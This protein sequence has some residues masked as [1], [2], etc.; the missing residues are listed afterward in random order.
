MRRRQVDR[1]I[2]RNAAFWDWR[3][4]GTGRPPSLDQGS[5]A[6]HVAGN[7][8]EYGIHIPGSANNSMPNQCDPADQHV[9]N[10]G[11][12]EV[13]KNAAEAS[14]RVA[15][16]SSIACTLRAMPSAS[17]SSGSRAASWMRR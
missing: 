11:A 17:S 9:A 2:P 5:N 10:T 1:P 8:I 12:V 15:A 6:V 4:I 14:H 13:V 16:A 7:G 3:T